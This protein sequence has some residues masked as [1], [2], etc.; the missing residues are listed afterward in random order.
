[1]CHGF[2]EGDVTHS[3][4]LSTHVSHVSLR[5]PPRPTWVTL[6]AFGKLFLCQR[7]LPLPAVVRQNGCADNNRFSFS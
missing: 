4:K 3:Q 6:F 7:A 5:S 2:R 1:M